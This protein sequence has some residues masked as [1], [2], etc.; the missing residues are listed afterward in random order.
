M[1]DDFGT[2]KLHL[3]DSFQGSLTKYPLAFQVPLRWIIAH[4]AQRLHT[5]TGSQT[6]ATVYRSQQRALTKLQNVLIDSNTPTD[7]AVSSVQYSIVH[8][9]E[10]R[11]I[12]LRGMDAMIEARGGLAVVLQQCTICQA[13]HIF[14]QY[15]FADFDITEQKNLENLKIEFFGALLAIQDAS[16]QHVLIKTQR[17]SSESELGHSHC[18]ESNLSDAQALSYV[19]ERGR[20]FGAKTAM[21]QL[22]RQ[23]YDRNASMM[24]KSRLFGALY[25]LAAV[26]LE[27]DTAQERSTF[28]ARLE[29]SAD[30]IASTCLDPHTGLPR[31]MP[32]AS[33]FMVGHVT[34]QVHENSGSQEPCRIGIKAA[35]TGIAALKIFGLLPDLVRDKLQTY[36]QS[37]LLG[38]EN[39]P[40]DTDC[41][42]ALSRLITQLWM[43]QRQFHP[44]DANPQKY[45]TIGNNIPDAG[46]SMGQILQEYLQSNRHH[47]HQH[48]DSH[49]QTTSTP[50]AQV[51]NIHNQNVIQ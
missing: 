33:I 4:S 20:V 5:K 45:D 15:T 48:V 10:S 8:N 23:K 2:S 6:L 41:I 32:G 7:E 13:E 27:Y 28:L 16:A 22:I 43:Q 17:D 37:W 42:N 21:G 26:L 46:T 1:P 24:S 34:R 11:K 44:L 18:H 36:L 51:F 9:P 49:V 19:E 12:H 40:I 39:T 25:Q 50:T 38:I 3:E 29:K 14:L 30:A 31:V 35:L 47:Q